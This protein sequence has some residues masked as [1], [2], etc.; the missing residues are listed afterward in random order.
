M[1]SRDNVD[2]HTVNVVSWK[3]IGTVDDSPGPEDGNGGHRSEGLNFLDVVDALLARV[4]QV[5]FDNLEV[6]KQL[7]FVSYNEAP[8]A[9]RWQ[10]WSQM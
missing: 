1:G 2:R 9:C 3:D 6:L 10:H 4:Q 5:D 8:S 7:S